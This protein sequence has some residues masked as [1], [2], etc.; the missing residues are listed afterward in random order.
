[1]SAKA[2]SSG[3]K[4]Y[5][6]VR[7]SRLEPSDLQIVARSFGV[8]PDLPSDEMIRQILEK[9]KLLPTIVSDDTERLPAVHAKEEVRV[10][11]VQQE[12]DEDGEAEKEEESDAED[13]E[14]C[15][16]LPPRPAVRIIAFNSLKLRVG[17]KRLA[18]AWLKLV[19]TMSHS[20][21]VLVSE[22][23]AAQASDRVRTAHSNPWSFRL[24]QRAPCAQVSMMQKMLS[25]VTGSDWSTAQ[26]EPCDGEVHVCF[27]KDTMKLKRSRTLN[28]AGG[29]KLS[30]APLQ[31][32]AEDATGQNYLLTSVHFPPEKRGEERNR[33]MQAFLKAYANEAALRMNVPFTA[34]AARD[35]RKPETVH[36]IGGDWNCF[37]PSEARAECKPFAVF[38]G[39]RVATT[40]GARS[41]DHFLVNSDSAAGFAMSGEVIELAEPQNSSKGHIGLSDHSPISLLVRQAPRAR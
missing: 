36:V 13:D 8:S 1:M 2:I 37:P 33:Q 41:F 18:H 40:A 39:S 7:L 24:F 25:G 12:A 11:E 30:Y 32:L 3:L 4:G 10:E 21:A 29:V 15:V 38:I 27:L 6:S 23:P 17:D 20:D 5:G 35:A 16:V 26:S 14:A 28:E 34:K 19:E 31:V 9:K 22:V